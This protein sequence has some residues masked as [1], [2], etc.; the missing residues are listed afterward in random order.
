MFHE[1][2]GCAWEYGLLMSR[3]WDNIRTAHWTASLS[4]IP[5]IPLQPHSPLYH[6]IMSSY[7]DFSANFYN[8]FNAGREGV[9]Y[10]S[11]TKENKE[12]TPK[13]SK[14]KTLTPTNACM[15]EAVMPIPPY[16][17]NKEVFICSNTAVKED[18]DFANLSL[19]D[20]ESPVNT[21]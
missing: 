13:P 9:S 3:E 2:L 6:L 16:P 17:T 20:I 4:I 7:N 8:H 1:Q 11:S 18:D 5:I 14:L 21:R 12:K 15:P 19:L 10:S